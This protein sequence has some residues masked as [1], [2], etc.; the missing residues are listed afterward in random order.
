MGGLKRH[1]PRTCATFVAGAAALSG[2][3]LDE[4]ASSRRTRSWPCDLRLRLAAVLPAPV[5]V[6]MIT[7]AMTAF[8]T[9]RMVALVPSAS[10]RFDEA[11]V[12]PHESPAVMTGRCC[13]PGRALGRSAACSA[14]PHVLGTSTCSTAEGDG[15]AG[16]PTLVAASFHEGPRAAPELTPASSGCCSRWALGHHRAVLRAPRRSTSYKRGVAAGRGVGARAKPGLCGFLTTTP[17]ASTRPTPRFVV[18]P[19]KLAAFV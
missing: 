13:D 16:A 1:M 12:H 8:Y 15:R 5:G 3:P 19:V 4:R 6:G 9:W 7:A 2:L 17:G 18:Q 11:E 14:C 10:E